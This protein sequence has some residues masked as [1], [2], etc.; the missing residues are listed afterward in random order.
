[1]ALYQAAIS[2]QEVAPPSVTSD[3]L[4]AFCGKQKEN[5]PPCSLELS[6]EFELNGKKGF[7]PESNGSAPGT[8][9]SSNQRDSSQPKTPKSFCPPLRESCVACLKTVYPLER[10]VANQHV[11]HSSC[12]RC[13]HC[14]SKLR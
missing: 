5:V 10:L 6:P 2:K 12:F 11:Y 9:V 7:P 14:S 3:Q 8:P 4:D 13:S 1:M